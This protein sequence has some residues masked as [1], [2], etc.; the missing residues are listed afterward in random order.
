[1]VFTNR[2]QKKKKISLDIIFSKKINCFLSI[3]LNNIINFIVFSELLPRIKRKTQISL[4]ISYQNMK[5][6]E[7]AK[8]N[9]LNTIEGKLKTE[10]NS[11]QQQVFHCI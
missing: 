6:N 3:F 10:Q 4:A 1:M 11:L 9:N 8:G 5:K 2:R 7:L